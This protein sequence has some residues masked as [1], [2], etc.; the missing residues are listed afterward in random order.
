MDVGFQP[1]RGCSRC[2]TEYILLDAAKKPGGAVSGPRLVGGVVDRQLSYEMVE[3][4]VLV[5]SAEMVSAIA[6]SNVPYLQKRLH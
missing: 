6:S 1:Y 5:Q 2:G 4:L 3:G